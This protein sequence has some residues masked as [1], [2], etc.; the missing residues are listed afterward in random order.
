MPPASFAVRITRSYDELSG[1]INT[2]GLHCGKLI[3]YEHIGSRTE[4]VHCHLLVVDLAITKERLK[5]ITLASGIQLGG[6]QD[7]SFKTA[8]ESTD[9]YITYMSKG[10]LQ[11]VYSMNFDTDYIDTMR[12]AWRNPTQLPS[13]D[14]NMIGDFRNY[15]Y[16]TWNSDYGTLFRDIPTEIQ[17]ATRTEMFDAN[18]FIY[19]AVR[20]YSFSFAFC[21]TKHIW[22][23]QT[24]NKARS[25][26]ITF[27]MENDIGLDM[28]KILRI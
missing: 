17:Y 24:G 9:K 1:V 23:V 10:V 13:K 18:K 21:L 25:C 7:W 6:N 20:R 12:Q 27:C 19:D 5:Q 26:L 8:K 14:A 11:P 2:W 4:L 28:A 22:N 15:V 16:T 3:A